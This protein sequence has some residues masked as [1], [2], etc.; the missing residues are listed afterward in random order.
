MVDET[1]F[2]RSR[3]QEN[4]AVAYQVYDEIARNL[5]E[6]EP[7]VSETLA[8][9]FALP[10]NEL[11]FVHFAKAIAEFFRSKFA[12]KESKLSRFVAGEAALSE[13]EVRGGLLFYGKGGCVNCHLGPHFS[14]FKYYAVPF[15]QLG[16]GKNGFG[17]DYGRYNVTFEVDDLYRFRTAP[18]WNV[19]KTAPFGHSG[20]V[21]T[22][23]D[24]VQAHY[25]PLALVQLDKSDAY[26]RQELFR[27][28]SKS[29]EVA[30]LAGYLS[31][32]ELKQVVAFL[33]TLSFD[34]KN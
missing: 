29:R 24:A 31:K 14:D 23:E 28:L 20:S 19:E 15:P 5:T 17:V 26:G 34:A 9:Y 16:F 8:G 10:V 11:R 12:I 4:V 27:R 7:K 25:D 13:E 22:L 32:A 6:T 21:A 1:E 30:D 18:L 2:I 33:R 3:K